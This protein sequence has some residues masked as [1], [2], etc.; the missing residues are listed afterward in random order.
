MHYSA[1]GSMSNK[2]KNC[3]SI[4]SFWRDVVGCQQASR[5]HFGLFLSQY[6]DFIVW[7][8]SVGYMAISNW[9]LIDL[10]G[11]K[12]DELNLYL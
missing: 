7:G 4:H 2:M 12:S 5:T 6:K 3:H 11:N 10:I 9:I 1:N 8:L